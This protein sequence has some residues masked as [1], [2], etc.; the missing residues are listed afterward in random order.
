MAVTINDIATYR[1]S[2]GGTP[3]FSSTAAQA[4]YKGSLSAE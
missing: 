3:D 4:T 2:E 1:Y